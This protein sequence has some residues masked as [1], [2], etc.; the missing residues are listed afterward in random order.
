MTSG[1][2]RESAQP[3]TTAYGACPS[4]S[5]ARRWPSRR[6]WRSVP[7]TNR[8]FP[9]ASRRSAAFG[10][11]VGVA[12]DDAANASV[13]PSGTTAAAASAPAE[14]PIP[15]RNRRRDTLIDGPFVV[16]LCTWR[17]NVNLVRSLERGNERTSEYPCSVRGEP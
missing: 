17:R 4:A 15:W 3:S 1:G 9:A 16:G 7:L 6:G 8:L 11:V 13:S 14:V 5:A 2:T 10:V 12:G